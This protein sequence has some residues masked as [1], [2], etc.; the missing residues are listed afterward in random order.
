[1]AELSPSPSPSPLY[2][3]LGSVPVPDPTALTAAAVAQATDQ[4]RRELQAAVALAK[5]QSDGVQHVFEARFAAMDE[6]IKLVHEQREGA[7]ANVTAHA[8]E[9]VRQLETLHNERFKTVDERFAAMIE[10]LAAQKEGVALQF[11]ERDT[12]S[13]RESRDNKVA[14]D[15][16]FAAQKEAA[17]EQNKSNTLAIDKSEKATAETL[18]KQADLFKSTTDALAARI[19]DAK[20]ASGKIDTRLTTIESRGIVVRE[21]QTQANWGISTVVATISTLISL[22]ALIVVL[23]RDG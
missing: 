6:A 22:T 13:E 15:A 10:A 18:N 19:E 2:G 21:T 14:V 3:G 12:R 1:V 17:S 20:Q 16:A 7:I 9:S 11:K 4:L 23:V 5:A 8:T